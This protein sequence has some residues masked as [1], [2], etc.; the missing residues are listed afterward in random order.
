ML[1]LRSDGFSMALICHVTALIISAEPRKAR[2]RSC[3]YFPDV[4]LNSNHLMSLLD[5]FDICGGT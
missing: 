5:S 3:L 2:G 1:L 4:Q